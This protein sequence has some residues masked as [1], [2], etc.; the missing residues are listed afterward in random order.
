VTSML[1]AEQTDLRA[2]T[3]ELFAA[4][5]GREALRSYVDD[6]TPHDPALWQQMATGLGLHGICVEEQYGGAGGTLLDLAVVLEEAGAV[7]LC[8]PFFASVVLA[9]TA[10]ANS[11]D[12]AVKN[13]LL[14][15]IASGETVATLAFGQPRSGEPLRAAHGEGCWRLHGHTSHVIDGAAA[16]VLLVVA[17]SPLGHGLFLL[18]PRSGDVSRTDLPVLDPTRRLASFSFD[19]AEARLVGRD[20]DG[21]AILEST[22]A[23]ARVA[24]SAEQVGGAQRCLDMTVEY[25]KARHQ[26]G[27]PIASFQTVKHR[28]ADMF[29][30]LQLGRAATLDAAR[31][32]ESGS[33]TS[34]YATSALVS[35]GFFRAAKSSIQ[36]HG[37]IGYTWEHDAQLYLKRA[38]A[39]ARVLGTPAEHRELVASSVGL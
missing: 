2:A 33:T 27:R 34:R 19:G 22:L 11:G 29:V 18:D 6:G 7:L 25:V 37:G 15:T 21:A 9:A 17:P 14:P 1:T 16:D 32:A 30:D 8:G 26:F 10:I 35:D 39:S 31:L 24:L 12:D 13:D 23:I 28:C 20:G 5:A 38:I 36:L 3:R 4:R